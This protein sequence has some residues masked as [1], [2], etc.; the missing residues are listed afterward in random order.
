MLSGVLLV[1]EQVAQA[2]LVCKAAYDLLIMAGMP[3]MHSG[4]LGGSPGARLRASPPAT[5]VLLGGE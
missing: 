2:H 1:C 4:S 3:A 5:P